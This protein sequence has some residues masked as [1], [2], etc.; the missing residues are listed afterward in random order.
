MH[1]VSLNIYLSDSDPMRVRERL[2]FKAL[3]ARVFMSRLS[4][5][6]RY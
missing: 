2:W 4:E 1:P 6:Q 5:P 3:F